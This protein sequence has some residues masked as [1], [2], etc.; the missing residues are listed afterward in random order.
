MTRW[1]AKPKLPA[2]VLWD[3][4]GTMV[5]TEPYWI[6]CEHELV[7]RHGNGMWTTDHAHALVGFDLRDSARYIAE[8]GQVNLAIDDIVHELLDGVIARVRKEIPWRP[9]ARELLAALNDQGIPCALVTMSWRRFAEAVVSALPA[10]SFQAIVCGD[11][12]ARGKPHPDP[13]LDAARALGVDQQRCVAIED[14]PTGVRSAVSAGCHVIAVPHVVAVPPGPYRILE[15][16]EGLSPEQL[17]APSRNRRPIALAA[18]ALGLLAVA[19]AATVAWPSESMPP[20]PDIPLDAWAPYWTLD[21]SVASLATYGYMLR[22]VSPFWYSATGANQV[23][24]NGEAPQSLM[25]QFID[26]AR[27]QNITLIPSIVDE[28]PAGGMAAVLADPTLRSQHV[29]TLI[30]LA[31]QADFDGLDIDYE[32][33]AFAD[34]RST[35]AATKPNWIA[36]IAEL[37]QRLHQDGRVLT[38][39]VPPPSFG[40]Y[41]YAEIE[42]HVDHIRIMAYDYSVAEPGPIAPLSYVQDVVDAAKQATTDDSKLVLGI[43][44]YGR[45][46]L[47]N[48]SGICPSDAAGAI[49]AVNQR[50]IDELLVKRGAIATRSASTGESTFTYDVEFTDGVNTCTQTRQVHYVD[51]VGASERI[52]LARRAFLGGASLWA[53]GFD[54]PATWTAIGTLARTSAASTSVGN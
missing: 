10:G 28:M 51:A 50:T 1:L 12:V 44:L 34:D 17:L 41:A 54:D 45:N 7:R 26:E 23:V 53:L 20:P 27:R 37:G 24:P 14:S 49:E 32:Q 21:N 13:F 2:A 18:G 25:T 43:A 6:E 15:T 35:W 8:H 30:A 4:D 52:D 46:W 48:T 22:Q 9:G 19:V 29:D 47:T 31:Q 42:A 5:D 36:F 39:S 33:F 11:E 16:L 40:V 3:M 38:V